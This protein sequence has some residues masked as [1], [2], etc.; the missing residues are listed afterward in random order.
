MRGQPRG[1]PRAWP[2]ARRD[3]PPKEKAAREDQ[4][5][6]SLVHAFQ[7]NETTMTIRDAYDQI[8]ELAHSSGANG[9][10]CGAA[11][12]SLTPRRADRHGR[13]GHNSAL[14]ANDDHQARLEAAIT[15]HVNKCKS[16]AEAA[17]ANLEA[18]PVW[19][20]YLALVSAI[21]DDDLERGHLRV[22]AQI[23]RH[24]NWNTAKA[25]PGR[26]LIAS[27]LGIDPT[28]VSKRIC[29]LK[30]GYLISGRERVAE[31]GN[32]SMT[33]YTLDHDAII[34]RRPIDERS[35]PQE[36]S[37][38]LPAGMSE[39]NVPAHGNVAG[40]TFLPASDSNSSS[41]SSSKGGVTA[42]A[43][44]LQEKMKEEG[45]QVAPTAWLASKQ[46]C[47]EKA[48]E[49]SANVSP[50]AEHLARYMK[51]ADDVAD[52]SGTPRLS[53]L[54]LARHLAKLVKPYAHLPFDAINADVDTVLASCEGMRLEPQ[55]NGAGSFVKYFKKAFNG[56]ADE[57]EK[58]LAQ[59]EATAYEASAKRAAADQIAAV[60]IEHAKQISAKKLTA[61]DKAT[62]RKAAARE[63]ASAGKQDECVPASLDPKLL[64]RQ[65][66]AQLKYAK[67]RLHFGRHT[68]DDVILIASADGA[69][70]TVL[71]LLVKPILLL[72]YALKDDPVG[73]AK[74]IANGVSAAGADEEMLAWAGQDI[75]E[76]CRRRPDYADIIK[77]IKN[78]IAARESRTKAKPIVEHYRAEWTKAKAAGDERDRRNLEDYG[79][80][81]E[82]K[83]W[84]GRAPMFDP[85][86]EW[87][88][89]EIEYAQAQRWI[90][91]P[92]QPSK[93]AWRESAE[94]EAKAKAAMAKRS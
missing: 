11:V 52:V 63:K 8:N 29:H 71:E 49:G 59:Q 87:G 43:L 76:S 88:H 80:D 44:S 92:A 5:Q 9:H 89:P 84:L 21:M 93:P 1:S 47:Q 68:A 12:I 30:K 75:A 2:F 60:E 32:R 82:F 34:K 51:C 94:Q 18:G 64:E 83:M 27:K 10:Q 91:R 15:E 77:T 22:L 13:P 31:A 65:A 26:S 55:R 58:R 48:M 38:F 90:D 14:A 6:S 78:W 3:Q 46:A 70:E 28:T 86:S 74:Q 50:S 54:V 57:T 41:S 79:E 53:R 56:Q 45:A 81:Y 62:E 19:M 66:N 40:R 36:R 85:N 69:D 24:L 20:S 33:H 4:S 35:C 7:S 67:D 61:M 37:T 17:A 25:W 72:S 42:R 16:L 23:L 39:V 73:Y